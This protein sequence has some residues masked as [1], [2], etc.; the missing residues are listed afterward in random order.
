M[1]TPCLFCGG[2]ASEPDHLLRCDGRQGAREDAANRWPAFEARTVDPPVLNDAARG[3][4]LRDEGIHR[5]EAGAAHLFRETALIAVETCARRQPEVTS[6]DVWPLVGDV[7]TTDN[8]ALGPVMRT[9]QRLGFI[10]PTERFTA[11]AQPLSHRSPMRI[12]RSLLF[13]KGAKAS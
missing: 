4:R 10:E 12:W 13:S 8:R 7:K 6:D 9:A 1:T 5:V 3:A 2:D 11:T